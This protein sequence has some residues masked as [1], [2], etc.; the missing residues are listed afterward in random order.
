MFRYKIIIEYDGTQYFGWQRQPQP[1]RYTVQ[2]EIEKA[3]KA[4]SD[5]RVTLQAAGRTDAG[6]HALGQVAHFDLS[7]EWDAFRVGEAI[8]YHLK[9][10]PIVIVKC[11]AVSQDFQARFKAKSRHYMFRILNRRARPV[12]ERDRVWHVAVPL[13][14]NAMNEAAQ[15]LLG[16]HDF[17]TFRAQDCQAKSPIKTM[18]R[19]EVV[20]EGD[21]IVIY[22]SSLSFLHHQIRSIA[23]SLKM[24]GEGKW[25]PDEMKAALD[26]R[27]RR[28]CGVIAPSAGLY[29]THVDY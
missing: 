24:V 25:H 1:G 11:E 13:D 26:A 20:E 12:I 3:I 28:R 18:D 27:D 29:L 7:K 10:N 19:M 4:F 16:T 14:V 5:E 22:A 23:G 8:N 15:H 6:V 21:H 9:P 2:H 17:T